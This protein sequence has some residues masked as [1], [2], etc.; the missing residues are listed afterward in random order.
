MKKIITSILFVVGVYLLLFALPN[1]INFILMRNLSSFTLRHV[2]SI[3]PF[4]ITLSLVILFTKLRKQ[5]LKDTFYLHKPSRKNVRIAI[6]LGALL[7]TLQM[8]HTIAMLFSRDFVAIGFSNPM[9]GMILGNMIRTSLI[10]AVPTII[11]TI[12]REMIYRGAIFSE[13]RKYMNSKW[14]IIALSL[15]SAVIFFALSWFRFGLPFVTSA[16]LTIISTLTLYMLCYK[17]NSIWAPIAA[18]LTISFFGMVH[19]ML[20]EMVMLQYRLDATRI[21]FT[22]MF[23]R[24]FGNVDLPSTP[25]PSPLLVILF[26]SV[27]LVLILLVLWR[28][29]RGKKVKSPFEKPTYHPAIETAANYWCAAIESNASAEEVE[30]FKEVLLAGIAKVFDLPEGII[31]IYSKVPNSA[32]YTAF[33]KPGKPSE[34]LRNALKKAKLKSTLLPQDLTMTVSTSVVKV[35]GASSNATILWKAPI[36]T[37]KR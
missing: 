30:I 26:T 7:G 14:A 9:L 10:A 32:A 23:N 21:I 19:V 31:E 11:I 12:C 37:N 16:L 3:I 28:L 17:S 13:V 2:I 20:Q 6:L 25:E 36:T 18:S 22:H 33:E 1:V 15:L 8:T 24:D 4:I 34:I 5:S 35:C 29:W 27:V